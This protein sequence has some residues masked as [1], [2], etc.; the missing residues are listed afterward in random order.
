MSGKL[1]PVI[2]SGGAGTRLWPLSRGA[3]PKPFIRPQGGLSLLQQAFLRGA[4]LGGVAR[5]LTVANR[6]HLF[7]TRD[8]YRELA[9]RGDMPRGVSAK[10]I[11]EPFG[12]NTAAALALAAA[13]IEA[14]EGAD[15]ILLA[16]PADHLIADET[17][18]A[19]A[20]ARAREW[21]ADGRIVVF[22]VPARAPE[23]GYGYIEARGEEVARFIEKPP[24]EKAREHVRAGCLWNAGMFCAAAGALLAEMETHCPDIPRAARQC[25]KSAKVS[26]DCVEIGEKAFAAMRAESFDRAVMEKT[27]AAAVVACDPGWSDIGSWSALSESLPPDPRGNRTEGDITALE[28]GDCIIKTENR[29]I[30]ALGLRNLLVIDT[31]DALLVADKSREQEVSQIYDAL[32]KRRAEA[33]EYHAGVERQW[34]SYTVLD[35]GPGFKVKRLEVRPGK[36][37]SLQSHKHRNEHWTVVAGEA[38]VT[39]GDETVTLRANQSAYI[40]RT[41]KHRLANL[42]KKPLVVIEVQTGGYLGEDDIVRYQTD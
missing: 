2:L 37:L 9:E 32:K 25:L 14:A 20:V 1:T 18:F 29:V 21:A 6:A 10:F 26:D 11:L 13:R 31:A 34:G 8:H 12:R 36:R 5:V 4:R 28:C 23:S 42:T 3:H 41:H 33:H 40:A 17:A 27:A 16:L 35:S 19:S 38:T 22:G 7:T 30:G 39:N 24:P 15:A